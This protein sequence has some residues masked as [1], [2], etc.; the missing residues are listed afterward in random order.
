MRLGVYSGWYNT[1]LG[2]LNNQ[3]GS[4]DYWSSTVLST[5]NALNL[6]F[7]STVVLPGTGTP[8]KFTGNAVRCVL[9]PRA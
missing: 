6:G 2:G 7:Y 3:N 5:N 8:G 1:N 4:G 9:D